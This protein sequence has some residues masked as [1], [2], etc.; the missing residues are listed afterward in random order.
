MRTWTSFLLNFLTMRQKKLHNY[1]I[2][3]MGV[4]LKRR[5]KPQIPRK[6][7][8]AWIWSIPCFGVII[9]FFDSW[10]YKFLNWTAKRFSVY[11]ILWNKFG[12][13]TD[14]E[15]CAHHTGI[16]SN[17]YSD[18]DIYNISIVVSFKVKTSM[19]LMICN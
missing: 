17:V 3:S 8:Y 16:D 6:C 5:N 11:G 7:I 13:K 15:L 9:L 12:H 10:E 14:N 4:F 1:Y 19:K 2:G 18:L